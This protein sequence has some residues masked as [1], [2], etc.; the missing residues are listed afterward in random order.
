MRTS[1]KTDALYPALDVAMKAIVQPVKNKV[2]TF[3]KGH[4]YADLQAVNASIQPALEKAEL[5]MVQSADGNEWCCRIIEWA[6]GQWIEGRMPL[7]PKAADPQSL[8]IAVT[9]VRRYL[10][11][12]MLGLVAEDDTDGNEPPV[13][14]LLDT[15]VKHFNAA[16]SLERLEKYYAAACNRNLPRAHHGQMVKA[17]EQAK[18]AFGQK[19]TEEQANE[20]F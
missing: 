2:N 5:I 17:Y 18:Q 15:I 12:A 3:F 7:T 1:E 9:Y 11:C 20:V 14:D 8:G 16:T 10:P 13:K 19:S 6:T 4:Q